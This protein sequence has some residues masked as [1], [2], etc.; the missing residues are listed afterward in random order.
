MPPSCVRAAFIDFLSSENKWTLFVDNV[1]DGVPGEF[2]RKPCDLDLYLKVANN[3]LHMNNTI[4]NNYNPV[5]NY[6][7]SFMASF[8]FKPVS[9]TKSKNNTISETQEMFA[10]YYGFTGSDDYPKEIVFKN[11]K[12]GPFCDSLCITETFLRVWA[13]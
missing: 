3:T 2:N 9:I 8:H 11:A 12:E 13:V 5:L 6:F 1:A 10:R 7:K 4:N